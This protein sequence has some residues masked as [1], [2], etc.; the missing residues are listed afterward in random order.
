MTSSSCVHFRVIGKAG[1]T[2][3]HPTLNAIP[4]LFLRAFD[5]SCRKILHERRTWSR[6]KHH[7]WRTKHGLDEAVLWAFETAPSEL[8]AKVAN[9]GGRDSSGDE[10]ENLLFASHYHIMGLERVLMMDGGGDAEGLLAC[11]D[12]ASEDKPKTAAQLRKVHTHRQT[13]WDMMMQLNFG[14]WCCCCA[15]M[16]FFPLMACVKLWEGNVLPIG[17]WG[18]LNLGLISHWHN[19]EIRTCGRGFSG[20]GSGMKLYQIELLGLFLFSTSFSPSSELNPPSDLHTYGRFG[21]WFSLIFGLSCTV[22][23]RK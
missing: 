22:P 11:I 4:F 19:P 15:V 12:M 2:R 14:M 21:F 5:I 23:S 20:V 3:Y 6:W 18:Y 1:P 9:V 7:R 10:L 8:Q 13:N 17:S 16:S